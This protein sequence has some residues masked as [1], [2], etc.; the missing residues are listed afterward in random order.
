MD[1]IEGSLYRERMRI[2]DLH[3]VWFRFDTLQPQFSND[4]QAFHS[5]RWTT[6]IRFG[7]LTQ[8]LGHAAPFD[9][10]PK[11]PDPNTPSPPHSPQHPIPNTT[12]PSGSHM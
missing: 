7:H 12:Q 3:Q 5:R 4:L 11:F 2:Q 8:T 1:D 6:Q 9:P 10:F